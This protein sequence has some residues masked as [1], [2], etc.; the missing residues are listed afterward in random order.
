MTSLQLLDWLVTILV[1]AAAVLQIASARI[2]TDIDLIRHG[3]AM[4]SGGWGIGAAWC[5]YTMLLDKGTLGIHMP[6]ALWVM[7]LALGTICICLYRINHE[8]DADR[9]DIAQE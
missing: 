1:T 4:L 8:V 2:H 6:F 3:R 7:W 9:F 5:G